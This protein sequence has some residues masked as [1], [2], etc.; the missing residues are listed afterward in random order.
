MC[1]TEVE[2]IVR[3]GVRVYRMGD[4]ETIAACEF[5][6][7]PFVPMRATQYT[8]GAHACQEKRRYKM[9][10][11]NP[12][13]VLVC[14][15][16]NR[17]WAREHR[18]CRKEAPWLKGAPPYGEYLPGGGVEL[19]VSPRPKWRVELRNT[20]ALHG[21]VST[22]VGAHRPRWPRFALVPWHCEL[23]WGVYLWEDDTAARLAKTTHA[24]KLYGRDVEIKIGALRKVRSPQVAKRGRQRLRIDAITP[25]VIVNTGR[26]Q[27]HM[28]GTAKGILNSISAELM[29]R[30]GV[31]DP[32]PEHLRV[33]KVYADT[34]PC[35][36]RLGGKYGTVVGWTGHIIVECNAP[37]AW[38]LKCAGLVG[39]G[40]RTAFGFGRVRVTDC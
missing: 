25:V 19:S 20:R 8:C 31:I 33:E 38:L 13:R 14:R 5:C 6:R 15:E 17:R 2:T 9:R 28:Y 26:K 7:A 32:H 12:R 4:V 22:L 34:H 24:G 21:M 36:T 27:A 39:L 16:R 10:Q 29:Q 35:R 23:D 1:S 11:S 40:S 18:R 30:L 3:D 37:A